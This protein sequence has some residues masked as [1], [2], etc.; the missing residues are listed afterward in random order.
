[1]K[2]IITMEFKNIPVK[3]IEYKKLKDYRIKTQVPFWKIIKDLIDGKLK[4]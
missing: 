2:S 3:E 1:M 4:L